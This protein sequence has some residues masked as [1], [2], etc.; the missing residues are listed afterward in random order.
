MSNLITLGK[1]KTN[2]F[3]V[4]AYSQG[5]RICVP[6]SKLSG[7]V[8]IGEEEQKLGITDES[9]FDLN[10]NT[11]YDLDEPFVKYW[12]DLAIKQGIV[13]KNKS[14]FDRLTTYTYYIFDVTEESKEQVTK[15]EKKLKAM[16][17]ISQMTDIK[18]VEVLKVLGVNGEGLTREVILQMLY[19]YAETSPSKNTNINWDT[20]IKTVEDVDFDFK[21]LL[22]DLIFK[23]IIVVDEGRYKYNELEMG[24][25]KEDVRNFLKK[26]ENSDILK[27]MK[28]KCY[29][30]AET[31]KGK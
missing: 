23:S 1:R 29:R 26:P 21:L 4:G 27:V 25:S 18:R 19:D 28:D 16:T 7:K 15:I 24:V 3:N 31:K 2:S 11:N 14:D 8:T 17:L 9:S 5:I 12:I 20:L 6:A 22:A 30:Q 13:A 10:P